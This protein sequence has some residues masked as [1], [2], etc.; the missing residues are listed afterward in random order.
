MSMQLSS[1][2][3]PEILEKSV[4]GDCT[5]IPSLRDEYSR[6]KD[7]KESYRSHPSVW[8]EWR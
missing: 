8:N 6:E 5:Y 1:Y 3:L 4:N 7:K 2:Q